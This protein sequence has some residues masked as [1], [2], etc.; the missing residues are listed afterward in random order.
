MQKNIL[1]GNGIN[2]Q[3]GGKDVY[4]NA[5]ILRRML[6]N[7]QAGKYSPLLPDCSVDEQ[8]GLFKQ[9]RDLLVNIEK[10]KPSEEYLF[11]L[12]EVDRVRKQ[13]KD[14]TNVEDIGMEDF[15]LALEYGFKKEDTDDFI[16]Q[17]HR[18]LQMLIL[19]GIYN[20]GKINEI[21]YGS[22]FEKYIS[23]FD[24]VFTINYD[25]NL[26]KYRDDVSHL[27]GQFSKLAPEY[28]AKSP[29]SQEN[30]DKCKSATMISGFEHVYSNTI[31][32]WYWLEKYGEWLG[33]EAEFGADKFKVMQGKLNIVGMSPCNDEHLFLMINQSGIT[34]VDY[35]YHSEEDRT[36][37]Q[38][39]IKKPMTFKKVEKLW[40]RMK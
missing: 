26:D 12:M 16:R 35:Y 21:D 31:M 5:A 22:G 32:S 7:M 25:S 23:S 1:I 6:E 19:D 34:S 24:N 3:F 8:V 27:H 39:K 36:R 14:N 13:Y 33:K 30:P 2:I 40:Q 18:E 9:F 11:L 15:F 29:F 28:D 37:M 20:D 10:Y 38:A 17:A 4:S